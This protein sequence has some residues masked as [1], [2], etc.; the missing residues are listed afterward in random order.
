MTAISTSSAYSSAAGR[1]LSLHMFLDRIKLTAPSLASQLGMPDWGGNLQGAK[2][3]VIS[4]N[5][6]TPKGFQLIG[7][8][9]ACRP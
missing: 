3:P 5:G 7:R 6:V 9:T 8:V 1:C 2:L 4:I